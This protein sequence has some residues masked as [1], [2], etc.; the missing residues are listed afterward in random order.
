MRRLIVIPG[1]VVLL[2]LLCVASVSAAPTRTTTA[3]TATYTLTGNVAAGV[4]NA[5]PGDPVTFVFTMKNVGTTTGT[6]RFLVI[7]VIFGATNV[8]FGCVFQGNEFSP[9]GQ[10]CQPGLLKPGQSSS[11][12]IQ[13]VVQLNTDDVHVRACV[14]NSRTGASG[15]CLTLLVNNPG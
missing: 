7:K 11:A 1:L 4:M 5:E 10:F 14:V 15:P 3:A 9:D 8:R 2:M 12:I 13:T 6:E